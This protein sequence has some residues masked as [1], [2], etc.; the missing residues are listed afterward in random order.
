MLTPICCFRAQ[1][2]EGTRQG[3]WCETWRHVGVGPSQPSWNASV[4]V[5]MKV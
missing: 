4:R 2:L 5:D 1:E 3:S